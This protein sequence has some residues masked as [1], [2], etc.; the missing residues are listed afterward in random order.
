MRVGIQID[1]IEFNKVECFTI[2]TALMCV[3]LSWYI[4][5]VLSFYIPNNKEVVVL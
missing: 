4:I 5:I 1:E 2:F 3:L